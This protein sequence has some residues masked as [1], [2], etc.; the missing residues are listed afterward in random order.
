MAIVGFNKQEYS[1]RLMFNPA[2]WLAYF[3]WLAVPDFWII[4]A[5]T[6]FAIFSNITLNATI[7]GVLT[8]TLCLIASLAK[9]YVGTWLSLLIHAFW[10]VM[11]VSWSFS[12]MFLIL[13]FHRHWD[14]VVMQLVVDT[15]SIETSNFITTF[16]FLPKT[17]F[18]IVVVLLLLCAEM[19]VIRKVKN[20]PMFFANKK[21]LIGQWLVVAYVYAH[22]VF[23]MGTVDENHKRAA[24]FAF[25]RT[26]I[27]NLGQNMLMYDE[28]VD[29]SIRCEKTLENYTE[30]SKTHLNVDDVVIIIGESYNRNHSS[31]YG[32]N[33]ETNPELKKLPKENLILFTDVIAL[34]NFTFN[35]L[36]Y[37]LSVASI[38]E[39]TKWCDVPLFPAILKNAGWNVVF[40]GNQIATD[41]TIGYFDLGISF[42]NMYKVEDKLFDYRNQATYEE[43]SPLIS[44]Y[45]RDR[46]KIEKPTK[47]L[48]I[49]HLWGQHYDFKKRYPKKEAYFKASDIKDDWRSEAEKQT[50][51][52]YDN[53]NRYND[54]MVARIIKMFKNRNA[55]V[56]F[57]S[58]HGEQVYDFRH[59]LGRTDL[60]EDVKEAIKCQI[61]I[62]FMVYLSPTFI[63]ANPDVQKQLDEAKTKPF[64]T[65]DFAHLLLDFLQSD[66][67]WLNKTK[68]PLQDDYDE[69]KPRIILNTNTDYNK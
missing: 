61:E 49:F 29:E 34:N 56:F 44:D 32:Y 33:L 38:N 53:A 62:P 41:G 25:N 13:L 42:L 69:K 27:Y 58:D 37:I 9:K 23:F 36:R 6:T 21:L 30:H 54:K 12:Q 50:V 24:Y 20:I 2:I 64:M 63:S 4:K 28:F 57:F 15:N 67:K 7:Y 19:W 46:K 60:K 55:A 68:S 43:D 3:I 14:V 59:E 11:I 35:C 26:T 16:L 10:H 17:M 1:G 31:L 40:M 66:S 47:N 22:S 8:W 39:K 5:P 18:L 51:A 65:D 45:E 52:E 48:I